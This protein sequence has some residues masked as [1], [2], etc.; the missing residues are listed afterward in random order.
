MGNRWGN[1]C[2]VVVSGKEGQWEHVSRYGS[3]YR[4]RGIWY[5]RMAQPQVPPSKNS[6]THKVAFPC[7]PSHN[8]NRNAKTEMGT[9]K[10]RKGSVGGVSEGVVV[11]AICGYSDQRGSGY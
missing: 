4:V 1:R 9:E 5:T 11:M 7:V 6:E 10:T 8:E 3:G 2:I